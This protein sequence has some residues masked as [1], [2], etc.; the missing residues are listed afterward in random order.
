MGNMYDE[1]FKEYHYFESFGVFYIAILLNKNATLN[2][3]I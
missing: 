3:I 2:Q 1:E